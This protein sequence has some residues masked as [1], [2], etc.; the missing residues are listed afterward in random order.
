MGVERRGGEGEELGFSLSH[1][2]SLS[3]LKGAARDDG[4]GARVSARG[5]GQ[6]CR[7][8]REGE[9]GRQR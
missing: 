7:K 8:G 6:S 3:F 4:A 9:R 1:T 2:L 5:P